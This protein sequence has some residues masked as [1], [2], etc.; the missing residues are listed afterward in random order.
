MS[1]PQTESCDL[2]KEVFVQDLTLLT[3]SEGCKK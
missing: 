3:Y 1:Y 2:R